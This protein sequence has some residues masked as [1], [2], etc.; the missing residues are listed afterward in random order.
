MIFDFLKSRKIKTLENKRICLR[1]II[2]ETQSRR[3]K[4][5]LWIEIRTN[6]QRFVETHE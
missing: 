6:K 3:S 2:K 4:L 1:D 5:S